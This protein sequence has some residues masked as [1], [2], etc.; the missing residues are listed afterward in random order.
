MS[1]KLKPN[2]YSAFA[3][4]RYLGDI[5][6]NGTGWMIGNYVPAEPHAR[7][8]ELGWYPTLAAAKRA[9]EEVKR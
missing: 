7:W 4:S 8:V 3:G 2:R 6:Q 9:I 5:A 1:V